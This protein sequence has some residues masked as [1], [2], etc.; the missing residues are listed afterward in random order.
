MKLQ[1]VFFLKRLAQ[2]LWLDY[3]SYEKIKFDNMEPN[4]VDYVYK[5]V[6]YLTG[7]KIQSKVCLTKHINISI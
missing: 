1:A 6:T 5:N 4:I 2:W 3:S 7:T